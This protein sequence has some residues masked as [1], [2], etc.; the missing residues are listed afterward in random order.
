MQADKPKGF[1][2][3]ADEAIIARSVAALRRAGIRRFVFVVGWRKEFYLEWCARFCPV[4]V[5]VENVDYASTGSLRSLLLGAMP[6]EAR[7]RF[8][9]RARPWPAGS[10]TAM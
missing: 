2:E 7:A 4:A 3:I 6:A 10:E 5:C 9:A 1:V 8:M